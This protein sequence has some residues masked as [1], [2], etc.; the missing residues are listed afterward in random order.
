MDMGK[1]KISEFLVYKWR[2]QIGYSLVL[3][4]L[5]AAL[6]FVALFLPG[7][8]SPQEIQASIH[9]SS[10]SLSHL[11]SLNIVNLPYY[12]L[13]KTIFF[14]FGVTILTIKLPSLILALFSV[15]G[16]VFLLRQWFRPRIAVLAS[17]IAITTGQFLFIAQNGTPEI[18]FLFWPVWLMLLASIISSREKRRVRHIVLFCII[19]ALSLYTPLSIYVL[20]VFAAATLTHPHLRF[21]ILKKLPKRKFIPGIIFTAI[22]L[23]PLGYYLIRDPEIAL[24]LLSIPTK[25]PDFGANLATLANQYFSF[26]NP[27]GSTSITPVF[28]LGSF[29]LIVV[30]AYRVFKTRSTAKS[31][32]LA[33][34]T[35][36]IVPFIILT[37]NYSGITFLPLVI[38]LASGLNWLLSDWY[39][40]FPLNPYARVA[41]LIPVVI[42]V[43]A[44]VFSGVNRYAYSY[45]FDP[46]V[47]NSFSYDLRLIPKD[48]KFLLVSS[49][50]FD[51]YNVVSRYNKQF[52]AVTTRPDTNEYLA[53]RATRNL[54][55]GYQVKQIITT[56]LSIES[57]RFYLY[58]KSNI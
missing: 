48:T 46:Q 41:G 26:V 12:L 20:I 15:I 22:I 31:Y 5:V 49:S 10:I 45:K 33:F 47:V 14:A 6:L 52:V 8:L 57:D 44:L 55:S 37:P 25:W 56:P 4:C 16:L 2:Y 1:F 30:G 27:G 51:F 39:E 9:S 50:E 36:L 17:L 11:D 28:E 42:L 24:S 19:A 3:I 53:S 40:L 21:N 7:G 54:P 34:W 38:L 29:L 13:Q 32:T 18:L 58:Q 35:V 23:I 43:S